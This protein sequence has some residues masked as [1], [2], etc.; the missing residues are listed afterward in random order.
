VT[1]S[2]WLRWGNNLTLAAINVIVVRA[3]FPL[4]AVGAAAAAATHGWGLLNNLPV[5]PLL[6]VPVAIVVFDLVLWGQHR[7]FHAVPVLWRLH[8]VH[9]ADVEFDVS[10]G[11]RFHPLEMLVSMLIKIAAVI[12]LGAPVV[13]VVAFELILNATS[14]FNH[15]NAGLPAWLERRVRLF[16]VTPDMHRIHHSTEADEM[17]RNFGFNLSLWDRLFRTYRDAPRGGNEGMTIG[18]LPWRGADAIITLPRLLGMPF[19]REP[20]AA[21]GDT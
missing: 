14:M 8:R 18:L 4:A 17:N 13:A 16:V 21:G 10:T 5:I 3:L 1:L 6:A 7:L 11:L 20:A 19:R 9:H 15:A 2:K 12:A